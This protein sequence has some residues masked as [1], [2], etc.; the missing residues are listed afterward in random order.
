MY[1][2]GHDYS[3]VVRYTPNF[4]NPT[5]VAG[6]AGSS[7]TALHLLTKP[8]GLAVDSS[9]NVYIA[10]RDGER[11]VRWAPN[12]VNGTIVVDPPTGTKF[13]GLLLSLYS[14]NQVYVSSEE[15]DAV[16]LWTFGSSTPTVTLTAVNSS[17]NVLTN[18]RGIKY[19]SYGNLYVADRGN[20]R[21]VMYCNN[22]TTGRVAIT[23]TGSPTLNT[24]MD[25]AFDSDQNLYVSDE[26]LNQVYKYNR[27]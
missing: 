19:D 6:V 11:V 2:T 7:G 1:I 5:T 3:R 13:Y 14:S 17:T 21:V 27:L 22:S 8:L 23:G 24:V 10:E 18:P 20:K 16:Y 15:K 12:A 25:V 4:T 26:S 9:L